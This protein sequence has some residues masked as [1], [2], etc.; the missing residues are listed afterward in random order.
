LL[1]C[2]NYIFQYFCDRQKSKQHLQAS[3]VVKGKKNSGLNLLGQ[4]KGVFK[5]GFLSMVMLWMGSACQLE[6]LNDPI[7]VA[8]IDDEF[9]IDLWETL[10]TSP[11]FE[12]H[13][14]TIKDEECLNVVIDAS[15][16]KR[17]QT[18]N[19]RIDNIIQPA[20]CI[21]GLAPAMA[22]LD[23][24]S[25]PI[26]FYNFSIDLKNTIFNNGQ[27]TITDERYSLEMETED[28]IIL[29]RSDLYRIPDQTLWG[30]VNFDLGQNDLAEAF[31]QELAAFADP[32]NFKRGYY[33]HFTINNDA[34]DVTVTSQPIDFT[35]LPFAQRYDRADEVAITQLVE[36]YRS[37]GLD[38]MLQNELGELF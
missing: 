19:I 29:V 21:E 25:M 9:Y 1:T 15:P 30:Y 38:I 16:L 37:Q 2:S 14:E 17:P 3:A 18:V 28:G 12:I 35:L 4:M 26:G 6:S 13:I 36:S 22:Q 7:V 8:D 11:R 33:G 10:G 23:L 32:F 27:L 34:N 5:I 31:T 24:G 20:D